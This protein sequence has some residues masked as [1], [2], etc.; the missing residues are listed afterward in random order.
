MNQREVPKI[1][2]IGIPKQ[3][4]DNETRVAVIPSVVKK[5]VKLGN[6]VVVE[7]GAGLKA[8]YLDQAYSD[9]GAEIVNH[10]AARETVWCGS[11]LVLTIEPPSINDAQSM[12]EGSV[13][14]G[15]LAPLANHELVKTL[16]DNGVTG[17][18]MEFLPRTSRAQ[19]MDVLS[20]QANL[21]GYKAVLLGA[22]YCPKM[23][24]MMITAA[25]TIAPAKVFIIGAGVAG[26]QAIATAKR[27]GAT[28]EAFDVRAVTKEQV[29]SLGARFVELPTAAQDDATTGGYAKEQTEEERQQQTELMSKHVIGADITVTTAAVFGKAPPMLIPKPVVDSMK[30][31]SVIVDLAANKEHGRGNCELTKPGEIVTTDNG[32]II[33]GLEN[34]PSLLSSNASQVYANN[35]FSFCSEFI[36]DGNIQLN[37][38]DELIKGTMITHAKQVVN[39]L[40]AGSVS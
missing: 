5:L 39:E 21:G 6:K 8:H 35:M 27:L 11:D 37:M 2:Q 32:V 36:K 29:M 9:A 12:K 1:M 23:F 30:S 16:R 7:S 24:P 4:A 28:V 10:E 31:G 40:V 17:F 38:E 19:S 20:S 14:V 34:L 15:M 13:L 18:S 26:L 3:S 33:I 25:G 22:D